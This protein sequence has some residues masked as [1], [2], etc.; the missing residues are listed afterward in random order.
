MAVIS[1]SI[2]AHTPTQAVAGLALI[3]TGITSYALN[4][5]DRAVR[6][7]SHERDRL[8]EELKATRAEHMRYVVAKAFVDREAEELCRNME[9]AEQENAAYLASQTARVMA[10]AAAEREELL[11]DVEDR[12]SSLKRQ[13]FLQGFDAGLR[14]IALPPTAPTTGAVVIQMPRAAIGSNPNA[15]GHG[16]H[17]P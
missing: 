7:T 2:P 17:T 5:I 15:A 8:Q 10:L 13:G 6:D 3:L 11:A 9:L 12:E 4:V 14:G 1:A 16:V